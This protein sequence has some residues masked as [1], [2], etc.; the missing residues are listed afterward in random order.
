MVITG[1]PLDIFSET[2]HEVRSPCGEKVSEPDFCGNFSF[3]PNWA[4]MDLL[5]IFQIPVPVIEGNPFS[6]RSRPKI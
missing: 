3:C 1:E 2:L 5:Y 6:T 4:K